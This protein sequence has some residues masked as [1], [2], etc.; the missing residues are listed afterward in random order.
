MKILQYYIIYYKEF[1]KFN[2]IINNY[3]TILVTV[4]TF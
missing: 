3:T 4:Y 1:E 2:K